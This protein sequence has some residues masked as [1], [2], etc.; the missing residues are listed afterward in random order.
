MYT[1]AQIAKFLHGQFKG[2]GAEQI[3]QLAPLASGQLG[4]ITF[5]AQ[6]KFLNQLAESRASVVLVTEAN[7]HLVKNTAIIVEDPYLAF[8]KISQ[9]FD[10]R[11]PVVA[12][13]CQSANIAESASI[14]ESSQICSG[15]VIG[16]QVVIEKGCYIGANTVIGDLCVIAANCRL[17]ANVS[18]YQD[19]HLGEN[20]IVHAG[21][22]LGADGFGFVKRA[23]GWQKIYQ[24]GGVR[25]GSDVEIGASTTIDRGALEHTVIGDGVKLDNQVQIA[26][27][28]HL[29]DFT[30]IAGGTAIAGSTHIGENCTIGGLSGVTGHL[31]IAAGT[32]ITAM[33]LVSRSVKQA[34]VYSSGTAME[35]HHSWKRNVVRFRSLDQMV[36]RIKRLEDEVQKLSSQ[37]Q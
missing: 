30:A 17:E 29:G 13:V 27:N 20:C 33:S 6:P 2:D 10:W 31:K 5:C 28:V 32:H 34:G 36:K 19:V 4:A 9:W 18:L 12:G 26:H 21:A 35:E 7:C 14:A 11:L 1:V 8:A 24:L 22:V 37:E 16:E 25:I 3:S 23:E 15:V